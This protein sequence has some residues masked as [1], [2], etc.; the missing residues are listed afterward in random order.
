[1]I[2]YLAKYTNDTTTPPLYNYKYLEIRSRYG[3]YKA[4]F[5][6]GSKDYEIAGVAV[7]TNIETYHSQ[8]PDG[9]TVF[10]A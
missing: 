1:M 5:P 6:K 3:N 8:T 10:S 4:I 7:D 2:Y 9:V